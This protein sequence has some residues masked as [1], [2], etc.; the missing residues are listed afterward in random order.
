M[1]SVLTFLR[2]ESGQDLIEYGLIAALV[3]LGSIVGLRQLQ[4]YI[5]NALNAIGSQFQ[6]AI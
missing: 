5:G 4:D 3:G 2:D 1:K 6:S